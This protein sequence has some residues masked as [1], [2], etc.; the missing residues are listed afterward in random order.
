MY[1]QMCGEGQRVKLD[2]LIE[3]GKW[4]NLMEN[5]TDKNIRMVI[6]NNA[7]ELVAGWMKELCDKH[8]IWIILPVLYLPSLNSIATNGTW[9]MSHGSGLPPQFWAEA[10]GTFVYLQNC[11]NGDEHSI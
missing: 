7:K 2:P 6:F 4:V 11:T 5:N 9:A 1:L 3:F 10:M 8:S